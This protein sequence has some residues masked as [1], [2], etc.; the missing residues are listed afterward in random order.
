[1]I[2]KEE[3]ERLKELPLTKIEAL[4]RE[5]REAVWRELAGEIK[6]EMDMIG[7]VAKGIEVDM[8]RRITI[9]GA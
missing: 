5:Y 2:S 7:K 4:P 8:N 3:L 9:K 1:M 6:L